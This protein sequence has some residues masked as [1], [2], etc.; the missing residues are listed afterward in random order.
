MSTSI[1]SGI[2]KTMLYLDK[3]LQMNIRTR[4]HLG[5]YCISWYDSHAS[6]LDLWLWKWTTTNWSGSCGLAGPTYCHEHIWAHVV[7]FILNLDNN[8]S[9]FQLCA[10]FVL[11]PNQDVHM[12]KQMFAFIWHFFSFCQGELLHFLMED[13][14][15]ITF[16]ISSLPHH[17][18]VLWK[19]L[20]FRYLHTLSPIFL[21][22]I[23]D[24]SNR[25][26]CLII[27]IINVWFECYWFLI[28]VF[29]SINAIKEVSIIIVH[30]SCDIC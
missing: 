30:I 3:L 10:S 9:H 19:H 27:H 15:V 18:E 29:Y 17:P 5:G 16:S 13:I 12:P 21:A 8:L 2:A 1:L 14:P 26:D 7:E 24:G 28:M 25:F 23:V 11:P 22:G 20:P 4:E 6:H